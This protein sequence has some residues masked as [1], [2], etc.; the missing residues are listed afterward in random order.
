MLSS[1]YLVTIFAMFVITYSLKML[2]FEKERK[3]ERR[4]RRPT[5]QIAGFF[6]GLIDAFIGTGAPPIIM[7]FKSVGFAKGTFRAT[8]TLVFIIYGLARLITYSFLNLVTFKV[9]L[10]AL[11]LVPAVILGT[12]I[13]NIIHLRVS[14][15]AF[16]RVVAVLLFLIGVKL[17]I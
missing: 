4:A 1:E 9:A 15:V 8:I 11:Y 10:T 17:L 7:Y 5:G 12:L 16:E 13:G 6:G 2:F 3:T 14:E